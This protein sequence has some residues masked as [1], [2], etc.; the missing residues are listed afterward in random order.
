MSTF[1]V[2]I[3]GAGAAGLRCASLL[4]DA[5]VRVCLIEARDR[6][7]GRTF[8]KSVDKNVTIHLAATF[9]VF[10]LFFVF[11]CAFFTLFSGFWRARRLWRPVA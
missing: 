2:A 1:D 5:G 6:V 10:R 3:I 11:F 8:S 7:G 9:C 4:A